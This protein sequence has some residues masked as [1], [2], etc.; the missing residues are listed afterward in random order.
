MASEHGSCPPPASPAPHSAH[1][2]S[3]GHLLLSPLQGVPIVPP[4]LGEGVPDASV[5]SWG[6]PDGTGGSGVPRVAQLSRTPPWPPPWEGRADVTVT[7]ATTDTP[8]P[9]SCHRSRGAGGAPMG[10]P[11]WHR[12]DV[13]S[14]HGAMNPP[15]RSPHGHGG[16]TGTGVSPL[17][18]APQ[19]D[20]SSPHSRIPAVPGQPEQEPI[21]KAPGKRGDNG[22]GGALTR[23]HSLGNEGDTSPRIP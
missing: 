15:R 16:D 5:P 9:S 2:S 11:E 10:P 14:H 21:R 13:P 6:C 7:G 22:N 20:P 3:S 18:T 1:L 4:R 8:P 12:R 23:G 17:P 19:A